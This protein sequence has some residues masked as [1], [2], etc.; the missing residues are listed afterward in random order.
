MRRGALG[1][2][3]PA[4]SIR[5]YP[6]GASCLD[7]KDGDIVLVDHG[8]FFDRLIS[9]GEAVMALSQRELRPYRWCAHTALIRKGP[10]GNLSEMGPRGHERR[11]LSHYAHRLYA[12]V[13]I[14]MSDEAR[15]EIA[16]ADFL[17]ADAAYGWLQYLPLAINAL[18]GC[19]FYAGWGDAIICSTHVSM[20]SRPSG[21]FPGR[22]DAA[23]APIHLAALFMADPQAARIR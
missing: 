2:H 10:D 18:S 12:V 14:E 7:P 17:C 22:Q 20:C 19:R 6:E 11:D 21:F 5:W 13:S 3:V 9:W 16:E 15:A 4:F 1:V 23:M 8:T